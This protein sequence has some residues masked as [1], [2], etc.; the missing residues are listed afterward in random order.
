MN[1]NVQARLQDI[2]DHPEKH[3]HEWG[4]L[5]ACCFV[6]GAIWSSIMEAHPPLGW[7]GGQKCDVTRGPCSCG[8]WH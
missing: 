7:N 1:A 4:G 6:D 3:R 2:K 5:E 8:A